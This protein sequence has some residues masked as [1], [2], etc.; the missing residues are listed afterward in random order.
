MSYEW[1]SHTYPLWRDT[2]F[3]GILKA[4]TGAGKTIAGCKTLQCYLADHPDARILILTPRQAI[5]NQWLKDLKDY[6]I[7]AD[8]KGY[9]Q[10]LSHYAQGKSPPYDVVIADECHNLLTKEQG[11]L[12][13]E[14]YL[15]ERILGMSATPD[16]SEK[17]IGPIFQ[18]VGYNEATIAPFNV[19]YVIFTPSDREK[20]SYQRWTDKMREQSQKCGKYA[21][22]QDGLLDFFMMKRRDCV[23]RFDSRLPKALDII[24]D[25]AHRR[26]MIFCERTEQ[27]ET[28]SK[29]LK[30]EGIDNC[31]Q[32]SKK[33][34]LNRYLNKEVDV[35]L[36]VKMLQEGFNDPSTEVAVVVSTATTARSHIQTIGRVIRPS[37][38]KTAD[39]YVLLAE[40]TTDEDLVGRVKFPSGYNVQK[41]RV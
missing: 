21:P 40:G 38:G 26:M 10:A 12:I 16:G 22:G 19:H 11:R 17:V 27:V 29:L 36:S 15:P 4:T 32:I 30:D 33:R 20:A 8:V 24:K 3:Q 34:E 6:D 23:Y 9:Q 5:K 18:D 2:G 41:V 28:L 1:Q 39:I 25:N 7:D 13:R 31:M 14:G 37:E 35:I